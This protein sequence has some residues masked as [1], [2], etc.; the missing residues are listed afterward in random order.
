MPAHT[1]WGSAELKSQAGKV[2]KPVILLTTSRFCTWKACLNS[3][4]MK[5]S[6]GTTVYFIRPLHT[7]I[8]IKLCLLCVR[9]HRRFA[10]PWKTLLEELNNQPPACL[11]VQSACSP[12]GLSPRVPTGPQLHPDLWKGNARH[13]RLTETGIL[14]KHLL[15]HQT[16]CKKKYKVD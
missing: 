16:N 4:N 5:I 6:T 11:G 9:M 15:P 3:L 1:C 12:C 7:S 14:N 8:I 10:P 2:Q 13:S